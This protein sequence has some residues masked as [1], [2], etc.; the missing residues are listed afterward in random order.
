MTLPAPSFLWLP[1]SPFA[2]AASMRPGACGSDQA[3]TEPVKG[4]E[5]G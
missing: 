1:F 2:S 5:D 4:E 3:G